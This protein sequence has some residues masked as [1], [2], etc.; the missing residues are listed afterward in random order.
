MRY[1]INTEQGMTVVINMSIGY[2]I[3]LNFVRFMNEIWNEQSTAF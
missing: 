1:V 3:F 2:V